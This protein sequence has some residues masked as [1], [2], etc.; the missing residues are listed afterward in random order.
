[1]LLGEGVDYYV[2]A[3]VQQLYLNLVGY[4]SL[5]PGAESR[6]FFVGRGIR[7]G[8]PLSPLLFGLVMK[9]VLSEME[10]NWQKQKY[11]TPVGER[12]DGK[13]L[14]HVAFVDDVTLIA[15]SWKCLCTMILQL[16]DGLGK[17]GLKLHPQKC[18]VQ[19]NL[20]TGIQRG[21][22]EISSDFSVNLLQEDEGVKIL[23]TML[24]MD[25]RSTLEI[26]HRI[27]SAW[28]KFYSLKRLLLHRGASIKGRM[29]LLEST[30][31]ACMLWCAESWTMTQDDSRAIRSAQNNM[32]RMIVGKG[33]CSNDE[34]WV[35]WIRRTTRHARAVAKSSG[36]KFWDRRIAE[37]QW[38]WA[39]HVARKGAYEWVWQTTFWRDREWTEDV[40]KNSFRPLRCRPGRWARWE[41]A[42]HKH[43]HKLGWTRW[44]DAAQD[45]DLWKEAVTQF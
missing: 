2:V 34:E 38:Q 4:V 5:W 35:T 1:M 9:K 13:R 28:A 23:G 10:G 36:V 32:L 22:T 14:T 19:C 3:A 7:Q 11:G 21:M 20:E 41:D 6:D 17:Y 27:R 12:I 26:K 42:V 39:G 8:D 24:F 40:G 44:R 45:R 25:R 43:A 29:K 15:R 16:R 18:K 37:L 33:W 31:G 30:V